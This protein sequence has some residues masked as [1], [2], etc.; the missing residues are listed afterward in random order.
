MPEQV[1]GFQGEVVQMLSS[2]ANYDRVTRR[3]WQN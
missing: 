1:M 3:E 2:Q